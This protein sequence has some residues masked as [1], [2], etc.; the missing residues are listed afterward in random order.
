M[1]RPLLFALLTF[2]M[3]FVSAIPIGAVQVE[4]A[5]R[6]LHGHL[7]AALMV[8]LGALAADLLYGTIAIFG[9]IPVLQNKKVMAI[10][11]LVG[12]AF[13]VYLGIT[14]IKQGLQYQQ[15]NKVSRRVR[16]KGIAFLIGFSLAITNPMMIL[17]WLLGERIVVELGLVSGFT[18][19]IGIE[20]LMLGGLGMVSYPCLLATTLYWIKRFISQ[21]IIMK[22][23]LYS[24]LVL[25]LF[26][27]YLVVKSL[28]ILVGD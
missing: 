15:F 4:V 16:H 9:L 23:A 7:K 22:I 25:I 6:A 27:I 24:G 19:K 3:G 10:F 18:K 11:W 21:K 12:G 14:V 26:S 2:S 1:F 5:T 17:W 20:F 8:S 28:V 13:I